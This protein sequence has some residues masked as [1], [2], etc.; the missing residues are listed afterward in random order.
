MKKTYRMS[1]SFIITIAVLLIHSNRLTASE[2][3]S[4][5]GFQVKKI[6][7][8]PKE[9][10]SWVALTSDD[11]GRLIA[12]AQ[13]NEGIFRI[14]PNT[15]NP[16]I[17]KLK[18]NLNIGGARGILYA[19]DSLYVFYTRKGLYR[20]T[21]TTGDDQFD[22]TEFLIPFNGVPEHGVHSVVLSPD[23]KSLYLVCG[24]QTKLPDSVKNSRPSKKW[25]E[26]HLLPRMD[27]PRGHNKGKLAP[28]GFIVKVSPD[29]L[30]QEL[31]AYGFRNQFDIAFNKS[32]D[33]FTWD[34]DM[35]WDLGTPWYRPTR[36]NH[37]TSGAD[38]GWR[39]GSGKWP[40]YYPDSLPANL[41]I[42]P[43]SPTGLCSGIGAKFPE[44]Y[45][46]AIFMN[47]WTYGTMYAL[48]LEPQGS[49]YK[50]TSEEFLSGKPLPLTDLVIHTDGNMYF[51]VGGRKTQSSLYQVSHSGYASTEPLMFNANRT[52]R[53]VQ[54]RRQLEK[55]HI[56]GTEIKAIDKVWAF[57]NH[58]DRF[59]RYAARVAIE[60]Q[61]VASWQDYFSG[62]TDEWAVIEGAVALARMGEKKHQPK[63]LEK[64]N[65][66]NKRKLSKKQVLATIRAYQLA[67]TRLGKPSESLAKGVTD[68]LNPLFPSK[69]PFV[70]RELVQVLLYLEAPGIVGK[71]IHQMLNAKPVKQQDYAKTLLERN[72]RYK[73]AFNR[74]KN[75]Q[76]NA[77]QIAFA[78]ALRSIKNGWTKDDYLNYFSWFP[79]ARLWQGGNSFPEYI[80][81]IRQEALKNIEDPFMKKT[82][83]MISSKTLKKE[84]EIIPPQGPPRIWTVASA[85]QAVESNLVNRDFHSG[86]NLYHATACAACHNFAGS[87]SGGI[88]PNLTGSANRYTIRDMMENIIEPSNVISDQYGSVVLTM[89]DGTTKT[90]RLGE[91]EG[92]LIT[93]MPNPF[94]SD[95]VMVKRADILEQKESTVSSMPAGLIYPLN[96]TELSDLIAYIFS[97]GNPN[98]RF[99]A[100]K[101]SS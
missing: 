3:K 17:E 73:Q 35:E 63:I 98:H 88:G 37:V 5:P 33:M 72:D 26:D 79:T 15:P 54:I 50:I 11:Q 30:N 13:Y 8:V 27:D 77:Q 82:L 94:S 100:K 52:T 59:I 67:F 51:L 62:E 89:K 12:C 25:S 81:N 56:D 4:L 96:E 19:F 85:T 39:S 48:H 10:G 41:E 42:G 24:N 49:T 76:P 87:G 99:F 91:T 45:Q 95:S 71:A 14:T 93:L 83:D 22:K 21:D 38:Y 57:L 55:L 1:I 2:I 97:G 18:I 28:G 7:S 44:K 86:E 29:G 58:Q 90:G 31:I 32:G 75:S 80:E 65:Q 9:S 20:L 47:D 23:K 34:A 36:V 101:N 46:K 84:R 66:L 70:N 69:D 78:F 43:G 6:Y 92:D 16:K 53:Q 60:K 61:P 64:L 40:S 74:I 68:H